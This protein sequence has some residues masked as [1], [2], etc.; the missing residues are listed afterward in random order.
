MVQRSKILV[1][2]QTVFRWEIKNEL[3]FKGHLGDTEMNSLEKRLML[4]DDGLRGWIGIILRVFL[5]LR[6]D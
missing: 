6:V 2:T 5:E 4:M 3:R 1:S